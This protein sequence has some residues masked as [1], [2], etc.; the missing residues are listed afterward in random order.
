MST[1]FLNEPIYRW[2]LFAAAMLFFLEAWHGVIKEI[3]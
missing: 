3:V 1:Q 2:A